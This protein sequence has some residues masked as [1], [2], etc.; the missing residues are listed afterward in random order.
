[1]RLWTLGPVHGTRGDIGYAALPARGF[2]LSPTSSFPT[3]Q[4]SDA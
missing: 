3:T 1:M 4:V 2:E